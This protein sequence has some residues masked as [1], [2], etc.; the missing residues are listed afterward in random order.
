[1]NIRWGP[2]RVVQWGR[3]KARQGT[4]VSEHATAH[5][6]FEEIDRLADQMVRTSTPSNAAE[7]TVVDVDD[8]IVIRPGGQ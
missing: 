4:L 8:G 3:D 7:L 6:A 2:Y 1:M 5:E